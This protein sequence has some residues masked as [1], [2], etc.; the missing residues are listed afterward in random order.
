MGQHLLFKDTREDRHRRS[1]QISMEIKVYDFLESS[2]SMTKSEFQMNFSVH[3]F[4]LVANQMANLS[5]SNGPPPPGAQLHS[6]P[7]QQQNAMKQMP[8]QINRG[9]PPNNNNMPPNASHSLTQP[10]SS[11]AAVNGLAQQN[12]QFVSNGS[13]QNYTTSQSQPGAQG[14]PLPQQ[15]RPNAQSECSPQPRILTQQTH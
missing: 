14:P 13:N 15:N 3:S 1:Q 7:P 5:L 6:L 12:Q 10:P 9:F 11:T 8:Q 2:P 4:Q